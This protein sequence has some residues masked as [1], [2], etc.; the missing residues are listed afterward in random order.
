[1][2]RLFT[3]SVVLLFLALAACRLFGD[4]NLP[5]WFPTPDSAEG[6]TLAMEIRGLEDY[7]ESTA[8]P[9]PAL[10]PLRFPP[11]H[12]PPPPGSDINY[13]IVTQFVMGVEYQTNAAHSSIM[14]FQ[15]VYTTNY[16]PRYPKILYVQATFSE[17]V[18]GEYD[19]MGQEMAFKLADATNGFYSARL[20]IE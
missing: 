2:K 13:L 1:M 17:T 14:E 9:S 6:V 15:T 18:D 8:P 11:A 3:I 10:P 7:A 4:T 16:T 12:F 19:D 20:R 5:H